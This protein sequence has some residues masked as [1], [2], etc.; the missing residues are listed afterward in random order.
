MTWS[1]TWTYLDGDWVEGNVPLLG[2]RSHAMWLASTVFDGARA[3]EG[4][5]PDVALH[6]ARVNNSA[7]VMGLAPFVPV[8]QMLD[9]VEAG[10]K[11]FAPDAE[12]YLRPMYWAE[13]GGFYSV[14]PDPGS[15]RFCFCL[16]EAPMP[17]P[18][19]FSVTLSPFRRPSNDVAP[20]DA[21]AACLY[22]NGARAITEAL[23]RGFDNAIML[24]LLGN[25]AETATSN[26]FMAKDG[27]VVTPAANGAFLAGIT[28]ARIIGLLRAD[29][30][31]V[32]E[33]AIRWP[34]L[35]EA[36]E[37]F[38]V[39]NYA[40]VVPMAQIESRPLQPGPFFRRA[41]ELYWAFAHDGA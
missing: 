34:E 5:A 4:V 20:T 1:Q 31:P 29:G 3:F 12:L 27:V 17:P 32:E 14:P 39:G 2:P 26:V 11:R 40:K 23:S 18:G 15:T 37:L 41:R 9:I 8:D 7:R 6:C 30:V 21:K 38:S 28:R 24:D 35:L 13:H 19:G 16:Y 36:D 25:V 22:P 10:R 33:R